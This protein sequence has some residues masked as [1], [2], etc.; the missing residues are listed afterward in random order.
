MAFFLGEQEI[1]YKSNSQSKIIKGR[2]TI[3]RTI[4]DNQDIPE[5]LRTI[6]KKLKFDYGKFDYGIHNGQPIL[7][8]ANKTPGT[9]PLATEFSV[10]IQNLSQGL[11]DFIK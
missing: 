6:R 9:P 7:Y 5:E 1:H 2:N 3:S 10:K 8:D 11:Y 4:L